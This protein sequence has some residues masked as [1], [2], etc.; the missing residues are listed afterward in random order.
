MFFRQKEEPEERAASR[1]PEDVRKK[2]RAWRHSVIFPSYCPVAIL[3]M[4]LR[5]FG[6]E[7][8]LE[9]CATL[10][11]AMRERFGTKPGF[12]ILIGVYGDPRY[13]RLLSLAP[14]PQKGQ[15][16]IQLDGGE[17]HPTTTGEAHQSWP[18]DVG[19]SP[20]AAM[21]SRKESKNA[22]A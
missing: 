22:R 8:Y 9:A 18:E 4:T 21:Q 11:S 12:N 15:D 10:L 14:S 20:K 17:L 1:L 3:T 16:F 6:C 7:A 2:L 13:G 5:D 19:F